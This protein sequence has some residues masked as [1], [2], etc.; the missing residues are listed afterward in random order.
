MNN[1]HVVMERSYGYT[2][3]ELCFKSR[4]GNLQQDWYIFLITKRMH[5]GWTEMIFIYLTTLLY[6]TADNNISNKYLQSQ[7]KRWR[8][9]WSCTACQP[10]FLPLQICMSL[11]TA[12]DKSTIPINFSLASL[13]RKYIFSCL[14]KKTQHIERIKV[15]CVRYTIAFNHITYI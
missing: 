13:L 15:W 3:W 8:L 14:I 5:S 4:R 7:V 1:I 6:R 2:E 10:E 9:N 11:S 12:R